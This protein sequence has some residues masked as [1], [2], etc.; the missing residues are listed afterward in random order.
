MTCQ[1]VI[2]EV[3][4]IFQEDFSVLSPIEMEAYITE[5]QRDHNKV[6]AD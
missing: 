4:R 2:L 1:E 3:Q 6:M 5:M